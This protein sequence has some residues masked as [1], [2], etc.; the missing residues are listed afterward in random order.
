MMIPL[1]E[2]IAEIVSRNS[3]LRRYLE[4]LTVEQAHTP[5]SWLYDGYNGNPFLE[6][7]A[8]LDA[9][10][11]QLAK[12]QTGNEF[13]RNVYTFDISQKEK[14]GPQ[15]GHAPVS[16]LLEPIVLP[17]F[18]PPDFSRKPQAFLDERWEQAKKDV[19]REMKRN[20][21]RNLAPRSYARVVDDM[22]DRDALGSNSGFPAFTRRGNPRVKRD[23]LND[24][25]SGAWKKYPAILLFRHYNGKTRQVWMFP[26]S[27]N[28]VEG[29]WFQPLA[30]AIM[31]SALA[32][33]FFAPWKGFEAVRKLIQREYNN[34]NQCLGASDFSSTDAHFQLAA[35][36]QVF[37]VLREL[38]RPQY[39]DMLHES[40]VH[41]HKIPLIVSPSEMLIGDHGVASGS[42][43]TNFI[44]TVFDFILKYYAGYLM[45]DKSYAD[46]IGSATIAATALYGVG[47]DEAWIAKVN[48]TTQKF[49]LMLEDIGKLCGQEI[50]AEK[51]MMEPNKVKSL[52]RLFQRG[53]YNPETNE[54]RAV[55]STIRAL[56]SSVYP[57]RIHKAE[58]WNSD[59]FCAR[60]FMILE[61]CADHPL[62]NEFVKFVCKG[63]RHLI[64]FAKST[65][66]HLDRIT[67]KAKLIPGLKDRKSVV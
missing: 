62:F 35:T 40:L 15:G 53:Y 55:Y 52:Q 10:L 30:D 23:A 44:E 24:A 33:E 26:M 61:N 11:K 34:A 59:M 66:K 21:I 2:D 43:W 16:K 49:Q 36:E 20:G 4:S 25:A 27:T 48:S 37:D 58:D 46:A 6:P 22:R 63:N 47:D 3:G 41:M 9:W 60:Q 64:P 28:I 31:N 65:D 5:R 54:I 13:E 12:L 56:K 7:D 32:D 57:E 8:V 14:W 29:S 67:R 38:F 18:A 1:P 50:K 45:G 42:N 51:T 39:A 17:S 19:I